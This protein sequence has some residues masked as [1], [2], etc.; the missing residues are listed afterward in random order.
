MSG[1]SAKRNVFSNVE[2][3]T[4]ATSAAT[5]TGRSRRMNRSK[6][7]M[8]T[9][10]HTEIKTPDTVTPMS[11]T[12]V[13]LDPL[14]HPERERER[15]HENR[16]RHLQ[17][18]RVPDLLVRD[19]N[20]HPENPAEHC[21]D[22]RD[23][24]RS[25]GLPWDATIWDSRPPVPVLPSPGGV[26]AGL[27]LPSRA[28][29]AKDGKNDDHGQNSDDGAAQHGHIPCA[30]HEIAER[31]AEKHGETPRQ[32]VPQRAL[33]ERGPAPLTAAHPGPKVR[34]IDG[35]SAVSAP[36]RIAVWTSPIQSADRAALIH[37]NRSCRRWRA[38]PMSQ[39]KT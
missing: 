16:E 12:T 37:P 9:S 6:K 31:D 22:D 11:G 14:Q 38:A 29:A 19:G 33:H 34:G 8:K 32:I 18:R 25:S 20:D 10:R 15:A 39:L 27:C 24:P 17:Q 36:G 2:R 26:R 3:A 5:A 7:T 4:L 35:R 30:I 13:V 21:S 23:E 1:R 28:D